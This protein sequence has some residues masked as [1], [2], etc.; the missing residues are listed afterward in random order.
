MLRLA[1]LFLIAK[2]KGGVREGQRKGRGGVEKVGGCSEA[3][4]LLPGHQE[5]LFPF[6]EPGRAA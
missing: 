6:L 4:W 1:V 3:R 5:F 2:K